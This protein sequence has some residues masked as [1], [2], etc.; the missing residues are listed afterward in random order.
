MFWYSIVL[1]Y[2]IK[3]NLSSDIHFLRQPWN[4]REKEALKWSFIF[5]IKIIETSYFFPYQLKTWLLNCR[6]LRTPFFGLIIAVNAWSVGVFRAQPLFVLH[7]LSA[8]QE[9][10]ATLWEKYMITER[11]V[12]GAMV[13]GYYSKH[14]TSYEWK[15][16]LIKMD[17][18]LLIV[19]HR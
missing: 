15:S 11:T 9:T 4:V 19:I 17:P 16:T 13:I 2:R 3:L 6:L 12:W 14:S 18:L 7:N 1:S 5:T 8:S 10:V